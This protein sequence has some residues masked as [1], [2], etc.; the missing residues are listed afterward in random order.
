MLLI[1]VVAPLT[2]KFPETVTF[3][4]AS[5]TRSVPVALGKVIVRAAVGSTTTSV[6]SYASSVVP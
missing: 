2:V 1:V 6:V 3:P 4:L 5:A